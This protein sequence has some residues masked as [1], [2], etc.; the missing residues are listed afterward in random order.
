MNI[1]SD[2]KGKKARIGSSEAH[3]AGV[4]E[5]GRALCRSVFVSRHPKFG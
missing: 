2:A 1:D 4:A 5:L 3:S